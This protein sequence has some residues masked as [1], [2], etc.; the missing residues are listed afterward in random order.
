[1]IDRLLG[2]IAYG[3][4]VAPIVH[5]RGNETHQLP[6]DDIRLEEIGL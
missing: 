2:E 5:Q 6:A 3:Y 1:L 4:G